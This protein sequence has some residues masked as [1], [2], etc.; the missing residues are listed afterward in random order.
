MSPGV[1]C[2]VDWRRVADG[3]EVRVAF[4]FSVKQYEKSFYRKVLPGISSYSSRGI[5]TYSLTSQGFFETLN[6]LPA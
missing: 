3:P 6:N 1:V 5:V 2:V 4:L